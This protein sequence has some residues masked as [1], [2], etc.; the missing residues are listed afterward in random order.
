MLRLKLEHPQ[1]LDMKL[2]FCILCLHIPS[3]S[4]RIPVVH[5]LFQCVNKVICSSDS[6]LLYS[7]CLDGIL[8]C[9]DIRAG[10]LKSHIAT[11]GDR[12]STLQ[13]IRLDAFSD[14]D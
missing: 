7:A 6:A 9:W 1:V 11:T 4:L 10:I 14:T 12:T 2:S 5:R 8:R 13:N 3:P